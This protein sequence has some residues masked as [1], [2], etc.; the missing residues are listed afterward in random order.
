M[1]SYCLKCKKKIESKNPRFVKTE[2]GKIML[3]SNCALN[4]AKNPN[5]DDI[6]VDFSEWFIN[7]LIGSPLFLHR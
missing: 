1:L 2:N 4:I 6:K 5:Y 7:F 3:L